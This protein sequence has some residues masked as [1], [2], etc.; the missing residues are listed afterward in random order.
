[1]YRPASNPSP[2]HHLAPVST[3][4]AAF[5]PQNDPCY[6]MAIASRYVARAHPTPS[7]AAP[8]SL[9]PRSLTNL[10]APPP[11]LDRQ[12]GRKI[13]RDVV[14]DAG[15]E[16]ISAHRGRGYRRARRADRPR[17]RSYRR[18]HPSPPR[19]LCTVCSSSLDG[20]VRLWDCRAAE[21]QREVMKFVAGFAKEFASATLGGGNDHLVVGA[22][23]EQVVFWDRRVGTGLE[24]FEDSHSE[25]VTRVRFQP[26]RRNRLFTAGVDGLACAFD[27][28]GCPA[29]INDEDGLLTVMHT[30]C[31]IVELGFVSGAGDDDVLWL[32][33]GNEDAWFYD[34][35][36]DA[37]TI[38]NTLAYIPDTRGAAQ[39]SSFAAD[40]HA[41]GL[42]QVDYL[43]GCFSRRN[44]AADPRS[45]SRRGRKGVR[46]VSTG[47][48][49]NRPGLITRRVG[50]T[51]R[52]DGR[53]AR[54][55][56][57]GHGVKPDNAA[58]PPVTGAEDSRVCAWG[59]KKAVDPGGDGGYI[60]AG[61]K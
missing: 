52:G 16:G 15:G 1:M 41:G 38:G 42:S 13:P 14:I 29:D 12:L 24:V 18:D 5:G 28:G 34:A 46:W 53:R 25:D 27:V 22:Q 9:P 19:A 43:V 2:C 45:W 32:L 37:D 7:P 44:R 3:T 60:Q 48:R 17:R 49:I 23:N 55:H 59:E 35:G 58:E 61:V 33:T 36:D 10:F 6:V 47:G 54:R 4:V 50:R 40:I 8:L 30:G 51:H 57:Q 20:T 26:G 56:R 11:R 21:G 39:R 31:A